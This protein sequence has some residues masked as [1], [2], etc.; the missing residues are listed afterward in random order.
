MVNQY[1]SKY[2]SDDGT[3]LYQAASDVHSTQQL[4]SEAQVNVIQPI[5]DEKEGY[6][7]I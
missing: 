6:T 3:Q 2:S 7:E 4:S 5:E 1:F